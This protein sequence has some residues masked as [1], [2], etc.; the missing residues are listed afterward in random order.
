MVRI[1]ERTEAV[2]AKVGYINDRA[3]ESVAA[4]SRRV[5]S[6]GASRVAEGGIRVLLEGCN[7]GDV[8]VASS[9][10]SLGKSADEAIAVALSVHD[11]GHELVLV[12]EG[13]DTTEPAHAAFFLHLAAVA[14]VA[15]SRRGR[16]TGGKPKLSETDVA[17]AVGMYESGRYTVA[18]IVAE[19][20]VSKTTLYRRLGGAGAGGT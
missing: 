6:A 17:R 3:S 11:A 12:E 10:A 13:I 16:H 8:V 9:L 2:M 5:R 4:Q 1:G 18:Q 7:P 19:T 14:S 15:G 20:G